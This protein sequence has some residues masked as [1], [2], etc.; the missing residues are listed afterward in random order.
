MPFSVHRPARRVPRSLVGPIGLVCLFVGAVVA[1]GS[2]KSSGLGGGDDG[3]GPSGDDDSGTSSGGGSGG[4]TGSGSSG[5]SSSGSSGSD[6]GPVIPI[7]VTLV[8][9]CT[10]G[11]PS[12]LSAASVT[13]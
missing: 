6:A 5:G 3:V 9:T 13:S 10:T 11:A 4:G 8:D 1:C 12:G 2:S 7:T